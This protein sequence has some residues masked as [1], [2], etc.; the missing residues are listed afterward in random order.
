VLS[1]IKGSSRGNERVGGR[2]KSGKAIWAERKKGLAD[3][4]AAGGCQRKKKVHRPKRGGEGGHA[5]KEG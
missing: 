4:R 5:E 3:P 1:R 2:K